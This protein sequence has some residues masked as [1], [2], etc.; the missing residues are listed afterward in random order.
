MLKTNT[1]IVVLLLPLFDDHHGGVFLHFKIF[2]DCDDCDVCECHTNQTHQGTNMLHLLWWQYGKFVVMYMVM[3]NVVYNFS[4]ANYMC[5]DST[6]VFSG[7]ITCVVIVL[8]FILVG[9]SSLF[10]MFAVKQ[11]EC[12]DTVLNCWWINVIYIGLFE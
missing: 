1:R 8:L 4:G 3:Y 10:C 12:V 6:V 11:C 5:S 7:C 2:N 9:R